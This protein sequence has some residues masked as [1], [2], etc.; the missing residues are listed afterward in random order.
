MTMRTVLTFSA[1]SLVPAALWPQQADDAEG[2][3]PMSQVSAAMT[4]A[5]A[6]LLASIDDIP[7]VQQ[8]LSISK[9]DDLLLASDAD[10]RRDWSYWPR[11]RSGL[12]LRYMTA[13]Q[14][15]LTHDLLASLLSIK[16]HLKVVQIMELER[17]LGSLDENGL[18]RGVEDYFLTFFGRPSTATPWA[19]RFEGH[20]VSLSISV[21]PDDVRVTPTFLGA[22]P[23]ELRTGP[24]A[25]L[26]PLRAEQDLGRRLV[27]SLDEAQRA[28]AVISPE[29]PQD[30]FTGNL[31]KAPADWE[32]WRTTL[33]P[34]GIRVADL[35]A[36]Q[37]LL[38]RRIIDEVVTT[39]RPEVSTAYLERIDLDDLSFAWMGSTENRAPHYY[40]L[41]GSDFVFEFDNAQDDGNHIHSVWRSIAGDYGADLLGDHYRLSH[42]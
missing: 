41:Q 22:D 29:A 24:L 11:P 15:T 37:R 18:P 20:H 35:T 28:R 12:S 21:A 1:L 27:L 5:A 13:A 25:G 23:A 14:R 10:A 8:M 38:V 6:D 17:V 7:R 19:W 16:G 2:F 30:I 42:R 40:R 31:R 33:E 36:A 9:E 26:R 34:A 4:T 32:A 39:Y 3:L